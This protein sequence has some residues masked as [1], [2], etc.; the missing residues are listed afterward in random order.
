MVPARIELRAPGGD[1]V[2]VVDIGA[3]GRLAS[4]VLGGQERLISSP[5]PDDR[6]VRWGSFLMAPWVGRMAEARLAWDGRIHRLP[7][8]HGR[9]A[10]HGLVLG[11]PWSVTEARDDR[12]DLDI[13][14]GP[15]GWPFGGRAR[16]SI[17]L[18][19]GHLTMI[20]ELRADGVAMPAAL[21][22]HPWFRRPATGDI[23][24]TVAA[25]EALELTP[26]LIPTGRRLSVDADSD[27]RAGPALADRRLDTVYVDVASPALLAW[28]DL[29]LT[30]EFMPPVS[31][32]VVYTPRAAVCV[33]PMTGW[34]DAAAL[35]AAGVA[36]TGLV[37]LAPGGS[38]RAVTT[39]RW[40]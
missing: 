31:T 15:L 38:L 11:R 12:V 10:L 1:A 24:V 32:V 35:A 37:R 25:S 21:G 26:D 27:L 28:P 7:A 6:S 23:A 17:R 2:A 33:E 13:A 22:W 36:G 20:A 5:A 9:H 29:T 4:L 19:A 30:M 40:R 3:G 16:Q 18:A 14:L 39:W 34:P 8:D